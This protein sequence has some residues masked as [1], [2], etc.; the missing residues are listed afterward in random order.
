MIAAL[1][2]W[3]LA[4][5]AG[6][7]PAHLAVPDAL[8]AHP[9]LEGLLQQGSSQGSTALATYKI[10]GQSVEARIPD[11]PGPFARANDLFAFQGSRYLV[12]DGKLIRRI[13]ADGGWSE[14]RSA[15]EAAKS[16]IGPKT[17]EWKV[18]VFVLD[19]VDLLDRSANGLLTDRVYTFESRH[20][21]EILESLARFAAIAEGAAG[22]AL[23]VTIDVEYDTDWA[24]FEV[25]ASH[26]VP[27]Q[28]FDSSFSLKLMD[29]VRPR[30]N[31]GLFETDDRVYRGP[32]DSVFVIHSAMTGAVPDGLVYDA[33]V[34]PI[35]LFLEGQ[36]NGPYGLTFALANRWSGHVRTAL[37]H[38]G[39]SGNIAAPQSPEPG[40][41]YASGE[42]L[43]QGFLPLATPSLEV[44]Q[45]LWGK[46]LN[47]KD[48]TAAELAE[49]LKLSDARD[50]VPVA[51]F[52][53][54][55]T[56]ELARAD[57]AKI[58]GAPVSTSVTH[59]GAVFRTGEDTGSG[60]SKLG[61]AL[62]DGVWEAGK[63]ALAIAIGPTR[64]LLFID[65]GYA[66]VFAAHL[67]PELDPKFHGVT[68]VGLQPFATFSI[69]GLPDKATEVSLLAPEFT[70]RPSPAALNSRAFG[71]FQLRGGDGL[72]RP[73]FTLSCGGYPR[74][75][76][77]WILGG[78]GTA[79]IAA[80]PFEGSFSVWL[81]PDHPEPMVLAAR[82]ATGKRKELAKLFGVLPTPAE[83]IPNG[84]GQVLSIDPSGGWQ[85]VTLKLSLKE[86]ESWTGIALES[87]P[88]AGCWEV[89]QPFFDS[90]VSV[91]EPTLRSGPVDGST[92]ASA[93]AG[94]TPDAK[95]QSP[96]ERAMFAANVASDAGQA[97]IDTLI[98]LLDD[99]KDIVVMNA[100]AAFTRI[101]S[102]AAIPKLQSAFQSVNHRVSEQAALA[103]AFQG[104]GAARQI[105]KRAL[106][107][108]P[109]DYCRE[110]AAR[111]LADLKDEKMLIAMS[112][113]AFGPSWRAR[114][115]GAEAVAALPGDSAAKTLMLF[116]KNADPSVR[117]AA[118]VRANPAIEDVAK[119]ML[120]GAVNDE[121]DLL[122]YHS[123]IKL[124][125]SP[126]PGYLEQ[127]LKVVRDDSKWVRLMLLD[128][129]RLHPNEA[130]R[131]AL[132][133]AVADPSP[134][135]RAAA[136]LAF[137]AHPGK[138]EPAEVEGLDKDPDPRVQRAY[139]V[140]AAAKGIRP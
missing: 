30:I 16:K 92:P 60:S 50:G 32:W 58:A 53:K 125:E 110:F 114:V 135:V 23:R 52:G 115:A 136:L 22:G 2:A 132:R 31:G 102:D 129:L 5:A 122:R 4:S 35:S 88:N 59:W 105:L 7:A 89:T 101:R 44:P 117:L 94:L 118:T 81:K 9:G 73:G 17:P 97:V 28:S 99:S 63:E 133:L 106:E 90:K 111:S 103:L 8:H 38:W 56:R 86:G 83:L 65:P 96:V 46:V 67:K 120:Y 13:Q 43:A 95:S 61:S 24:R 87:D 47:R 113:L 20:H 82:T 25:D 41:A 77:V 112:I 85:Q 29:Y 54:A 55:R 34:S 19:K 138:V 51:D 33:P 76:G 134:E 39:Y 10:G 66:D 6:P 109:Y 26:G 48:P 69:K 130:N 91:S 124:L 139:Q 21:Q 123:A 121:S 49:S 116:V 128:Y 84:V 75:G 64:S 137:A 11:L 79:P 68:F 74:S 71:T 57:L 78:E 70:N 80:G 14:I 104:D 119:N 3:V 108:G 27:P 1:A 140:L 62:V 93:P 42:E 126:L 18:K 98:G 37:R 72:D 131:G 12:R 100:A 107:I 15:Y 45:E 40:A 36:A 127:G